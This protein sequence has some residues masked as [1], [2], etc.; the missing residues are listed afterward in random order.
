M[1][2]LISASKALIRASELFHHGRDPR[3]S[4]IYKATIGV[5]FLG[6]PHRGSDKTNLGHV[7]AG[8]AKALLLQPSRQLLKV[9]E[10]DSDVMEAQRR[11]F[12]LIRDHL[13]I[14]CL[15]ETMPLRLA[16]MV[17]CLPSSLS[18][19]SHRRNRLYLSGPQRWTVLASRTKRFRTRITEA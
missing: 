2:L 19:V 16:G 13:Y 14:A 5:I 9:L 15:Y 1:T 8:A 4:G 6:S 17:R 7:A 18:P 12:D 11:S 10:K 3:I